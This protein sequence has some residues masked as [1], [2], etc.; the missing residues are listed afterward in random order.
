MGLP[1]ITIEGALRV[2]VI[3]ALM[4]YIHAILRPGKTE[5]R[6]GKTSLNRSEVRFHQS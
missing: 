6:V 5:R 4:R 1:L 2:E 3:F